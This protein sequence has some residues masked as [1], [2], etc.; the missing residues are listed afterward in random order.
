MARAGALQQERFEEQIRKA[1]VGFVPAANQ[2]VGQGVLKSNEKKF[3]S[4]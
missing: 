3:Y 2:V 1:F 4:E